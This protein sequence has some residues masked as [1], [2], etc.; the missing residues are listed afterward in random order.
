M[1]TM[2]WLAQSLLLGVLAGCAAPAAPAARRFPERIG[3]P[4]FSIEVPPG[5]GWEI[6]KTDV[7]LTLERRWTSWL[8]TF[9]TTLISV[10]ERPLTTPPKPLSEPEL[11]SQLLDHEKEI[12]CEHEEDVNLSNEYRQVLP[13]FGR[14]FYQLSRETRSSIRSDDPNWGDDH[15]LQKIEIYV[16][17]PEGFQGSRYFSFTIRET[18]R[19]GWAAQPGTVRLI[20]GVLGSF[21]VEQPPALLLRQEDRGW[22]E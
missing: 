10:S 12:L 6:E 21:Q 15:W 14:M 22:I 3:T 18:H 4:S 2:E 19:V 7:S 17:F 8:Q 20:D 5:Q 16:T 11:A 1:R 13:R 9:E